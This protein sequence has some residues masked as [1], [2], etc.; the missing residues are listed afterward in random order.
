V[1]SLLIVT[2][3]L[4]V[5]AKDGNTIVEEREVDKTGGERDVLSS[6]SRL[7]EKNFFSED[8]ISDEDQRIKMRF[9]YDKEV[10]IDEYLKRQENN[11][12]RK[13]WNVD[14]P[15]LSKP[16]PINEIF[17]DERLAQIIAKV[18]LRL[19]NA[20][21]SVTQGMLNSIKRISDL[22]IGFNFRYFE[23]KSLEGVQYLHNLT[24]IMLRGSEIS[25]LSP[26]K[27]M[28]QLTG[29]ILASN[30]IDDLS[31]I[32]NLTAL[33]ELSIANNFITDITPIRQLNN[34]RYLNVEIYN[35]GEMRNNI[36][37][38]N[39]LNEFD[40][41]EN[42]NIS[43]HDITRIPQEVLHRLTHLR[44][45]RT[46]RGNI[47]PFAG[48]SNLIE[49]SL[50]GNEIN[51][52]SPFIGNSFPA[53]SEFRLSENKI[54]DLAGLASA[55]FP[56]LSSLVLD[57]NSIISLKGLASADFPSLG[58]LNLY[59]NDIVDPS[60]LS[61]AKFPNLK[62]LDLGMNNITDPNLVVTS[63][64][65]ILR[66][67]HLSQNKIRDLTL[68]NKV[69][70]SNLQYL[71]LDNQRALS[72]AETKSDFYTYH[73]L[74]PYK[75]EGPTIIKNPIVDIDGKL[76]APDKLWTGIEN[77]TINGRYEDGKL[78]W[79]VQRDG[80]LTVSWQKILNV[81]GVEVQYS[82]ISWLDVREEGVL[83][84]IVDDYIHH[85]S[86]LEKDSV[87]MRPSN[88]EKAGQV[89]LGWYTEQHEG[90]EWDFSKDKTNLN[91]L[92]LYAKFGDRYQMTYDNEGILN[93]V[94]VVF[95]ERV[96]EPVRPE[97]EGYHFLGWYTDP[98]DGRMWRFDT[99]TMPASDVTL[100]ARY[101][102]KS[103]KVTYVDD[104]QGNQSFQIINFGEELFEPT[105]PEKKGYHF[106]GWYTEKRGGRMWRFDTDTMPASDMTLYARYIAEAYQV[107]YVNDNGALYA[108]REVD[109][110]EEVLAPHDPQKAGHRFLGWYTEAT[111]GRAWNFESEMMPAN[112]MTLYARYEK[113]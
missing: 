19:A 38:F 101:I 60:A 21:A 69:E 97:K 108:I 20:N 80:Y 88:P 43:G 1:G 100:Y 67:L 75:R 15:S 99:D 23:I 79:D 104:E 74:V 78:I 24:N 48:L 9:C 57:R 103:Y 87:I 66:Q 30:Q 17:P 35:E 102:Q 51:D 31:P 45:D 61:T 96:L 18:Y 94:E 89:F 64:F 105:K 110:G 28:N 16:T 55:S 91:M 77:K 49:L 113:L 3:P 63:G 32:S 98:I 6:C 50:S 82:A 27:N 13:A 84:F 92:T 90:H 46:V 72:F 10:V 36:L 34:L 65:P 2:S 71:N 25:N 95:G 56:S 54:T 11:I 14:K 5:F 52:L 112:D 53:L 93:T 111:G 68:L 59:A 7:N 40:K 109:F 4:P 22:D 85:T 8:Q 106:L 26:L 62:V 58:Y 47:A 83:T 73:Y 76:L 42:L 37:D 29:L 41:L 33:V 70:W 12:Q 81:S 107:T 86:S 39:I 44:A